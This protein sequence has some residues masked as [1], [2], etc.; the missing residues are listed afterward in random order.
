MLLI[1]CTNKYF[2]HGKDSGCSLKKKKCSFPL[3]NW[4][5]PLPRSGLALCWI[6]A[7]PCGRS[8]HVICLVWALG[9]QRVSPLFFHPS[10]NP[11]KTKDDQAPGDGKATRWNRTQ[12]PEVLG[13]GRQPSKLKH[14]HQTLPYPHLSLLPL[15][16]MQNTFSQIALCIPCQTPSNLSE[17]GFKTTVAVHLPLTAALYPFPNLERVCRCLACLGST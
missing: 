13:R 8:R 17:L 3:Q 9:S 4:K 2:S 10:F 12:L 5:L 14:L 1:S 16:T 7:E 6:Q 11:F 15:P